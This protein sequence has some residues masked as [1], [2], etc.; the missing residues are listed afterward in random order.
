MM[1]LYYFLH[2]YKALIKIKCYILVTLITQM[3]LQ[4]ALQPLSAQALK[5]SLLKRNSYYV[6]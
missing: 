4:E 3:T 2:I 1:T 6:S 5:H